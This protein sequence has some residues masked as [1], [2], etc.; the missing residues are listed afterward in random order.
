MHPY[1]CI[2]FNIKRNKKKTSF[3]VLHFLITVI[4]GIRLR[5]YNVHLLVKII[6]L[7][8]VYIL[9][10]HLHLQKNNLS[11]NREITKRLTLIFRTQAC[12]DSCSVGELVT[13][14]YY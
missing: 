4:T 10:M 6:A 14:L 5:M 1:S 2:L 13:L 11:Y 12:N 7:L 8:I 9:K 3:L